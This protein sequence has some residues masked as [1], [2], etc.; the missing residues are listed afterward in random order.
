MED[1]G[2]RFARYLYTFGTLLLPFM[3]AG[4]GSR[5]G[6]QPPPSIGSSSQRPGMIGV[7][8]EFPA[9]QR[10]MLLMNRVMRYSSLVMVGHA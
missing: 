9:H 2:R 3:A 5:L 6:R 4:T 10:A 1:W 7:E 8:R